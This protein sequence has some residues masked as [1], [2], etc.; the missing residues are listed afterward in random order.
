[1]KGK[2]LFVIACCGL[3][4][5][6]FSQLLVAGLALAVRFEE[7]RQVRIVEREVERLVPIRI[8]VPV[9]AAPAPKVEEKIAVELPPAPEPS[10]VEM[11][12]IADP[13]AELLVEVGRKARVAGDMGMAIMKFE[14]AL[15]QS[16]GDPTVLFEMGL[17]HEVMGVYDKAADYYEQVFQLGV[18]GAGELYEAAAVKLRDGFEQPADMLGKLALGRVRIFNDAKAEG[19]QRVVLTVP[20]QKAPGAEIDAQDLE[21]E[22]T[23]FNKTSKGEI[24]QL[25]D[26]SWADFAWVSLPFDWNGGEETVRLNYRIPDSDATTEHL[27]G[28]LSYYGQVVTLKYKGE[29]LDVQAWPRD[30]AARIGQATGGGEGDFPEFLS[31]DMLPSGFDPDIPLLN[32]LPD[33]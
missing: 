21:P 19:G 30:L 25:Q 18:S 9:E 26:A 32:P 10:E 4:M 15:K 24:V 3:G 7:G 13:R 11:P 14:E 22:V 17:V 28:K 8:H 16:P 27:F 29:V 33:E 2:R 1:M 6:A 31:E 12:A 5:M 20:I 23:F